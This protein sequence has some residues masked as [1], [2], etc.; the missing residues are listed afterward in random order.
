MTTFLIWSICSL[1]K[2][3]AGDI[4]LREKKN[5]SWCLEFLKI[6]IKKKTSITGFDL[7]EQNFLI[8]FGGGVLFQVF[9]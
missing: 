9:I 6:A 7:K 3:V 4:W 1:S 8:F 5:I 2:E